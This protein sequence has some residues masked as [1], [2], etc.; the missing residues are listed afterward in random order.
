MNKK[1]DPDEFIQF[2]IEIGI[3]EVTPVAEHYEII[4]MLDEIAEE[5]RFEIERFAAEGFT[6][7]R[8]VHNH[9]KNMR[10]KA[11]N[12]KIETLHTYFYNELAKVDIGRFKVA[13]FD[14]V[15]FEFL[16]QL[17]YPMRETAIAA[18]EERC[19]DI[20]EF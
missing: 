3:L 5:D 8:A 1:H 7:G 4:E 13:R 20:E 17:Q 10:K 6:Q 14:D 15:S 11:F 12:T 19:S 9:L 18:L 16:K 2:A